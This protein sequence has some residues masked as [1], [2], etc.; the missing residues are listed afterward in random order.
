MNLTILSLL[1]AIIRA[2][3][4]ALTIPPHVETRWQVWVN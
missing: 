1:V 2:I 3:W 4:D